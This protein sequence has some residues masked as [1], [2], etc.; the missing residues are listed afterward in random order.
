M[1]INEFI[2]GIVF[3]LVHMIKFLMLSSSFFKADVEAYLFQK[4]SACCFSWIDLDKQ[5]V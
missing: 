4:M 1:I 3:L 2:L 5:K